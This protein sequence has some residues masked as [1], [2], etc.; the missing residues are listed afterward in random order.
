M[1]SIQL[2]ACF[3]M[4]VLLAACASQTSKEPGEPAG[5]ASQYMYQTE[6]NAQARMATVYWVNP[7]KSQDLVKAAEN[8]GR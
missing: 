5:P 6:R 3:L 1:K 8:D 7:P 2:L 4:A